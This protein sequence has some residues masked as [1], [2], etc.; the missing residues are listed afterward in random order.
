VLLD[1]GANV[2]ARIQIY[3]TPMHLSACNGYLEIVK[4]LERGADLHTMNNEG[5]TI[6]SIVSI[7]ISRDLLGSMAGADSEKG[8]ARLFY[9]LNALTD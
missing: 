3:W 9:D 2:N 8:S 6:Q 1:H 7:R 5:E 4:L